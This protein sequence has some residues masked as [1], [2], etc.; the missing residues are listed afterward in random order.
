MLAQ[1][2]FVCRVRNNRVFAVTDVH[3]LDAEAQHMGIVRAQ[4]GRLGCKSQQ[5]ERPELIRLVQG[6]V[7]PRTQPHARGREP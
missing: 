1:S 4:V 6:D 2:S 5:D 3:A 7:D